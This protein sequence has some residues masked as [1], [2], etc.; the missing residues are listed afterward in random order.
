[1]SHYFHTHAITL[2]RRDFREDDRLVSFYTQ[3]YGKV[4]AIAAGAKKFKSKL[5]SHIEPFGMMTL[6]LVRGKSFYRVTSAQS[7]ERYDLIAQDIDLLYSAGYCVRF[8]YGFVREGV[9]DKKLF[10]LLR[11]ALATLNAFEKKENLEIFNAVFTLQAMSLLG[12]R[13]EFSRCLLCA[14]EVQA[15]GCIF[16]TRR[17][18]LLCRTCFQKHEREGISLGDEDLSLLRQSLATPFPDVFRVYSDSHSQKVFNTL[19]THFL[20]FHLL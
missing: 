20:Q 4:N 18:G 19:V 5:S 13:P 9:T 17:G 14:S 8:F 11:S 16:S 15:D 2:F 12:Y 7:C 10:I 1:M 3:E 6:G